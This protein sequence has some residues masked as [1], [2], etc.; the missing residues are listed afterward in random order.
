M[1]NLEFDQSKG[2][3]I[4]LTGQTGAGKSTVGSLLTGRGYHIIDA[5][6]VARQVV[7]S[8]EQCL[9]DLAIEF[10]IEILNVDGTL[11]R[12][13]LADIAFHDKDKRL[14]LNQITHPFIIAEIKKQAEKYLDRGELV[15]FLDAPTLFESG[16][17]SMCDK[18]VS[19]IAPRSVRLERISQ[20]DRLTQDE[21]LARIGAQH[22][23]SFY[24]QRSNFVIEN[25][26]DT[27]ALR[28]KIMEMLEKLEIVLPMQNNNKE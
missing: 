15:V 13:K 5:D 9:L 19:V 22:D 23:D 24:T 4:G 27:S 7:E 14:K 16:A 25:T 12:K 17:D 28:V 18:I 6:L 20:R 26:S 21:A 10:G 2:K 3:I 1:E 11:N 8:G